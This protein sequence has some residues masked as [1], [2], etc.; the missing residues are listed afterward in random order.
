MENEFNLNKLKQ[1]Y[2]KFKEKYDLPEFSEINKVFDIEEI[3][4]DTDFLLR[5]VRRL[6][7]E[8]ISGLLRFIEVILNPS[9]SPIFIFK[10][11]K[12][13]NEEDKKQL[14]EVYDILGGFE[15][16]VIKLDLDYD[17]TKEAEF[18]K[19]IYNL[20]DKELSKRLLNIIE[21]MSNNNK[22]KEEKDKGSYFG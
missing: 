15:L 4:T 11:I 1:E 22:N 17:E 5:R 8:R 13:I 7:S 21:K 6:V 2:G 19:R 18:I 20:L 12:K 9:N 3:D 14:S 10:L 16:E